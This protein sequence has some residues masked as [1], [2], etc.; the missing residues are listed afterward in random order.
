VAEH[1]C[2]FRQ[3]HCTPEVPVVGL[4]HGHRHRDSRGALFHRKLRTELNRAEPSQN[5]GFFGF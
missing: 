3:Q 2:S 4:R 1:G 5:V